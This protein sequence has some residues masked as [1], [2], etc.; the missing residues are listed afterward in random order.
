MFFVRGLSIYVTLIA[1][2]L[3]LALQKYIACFASFFMIRF[4]K[5]FTVGQRIRIGQVK[6]DVRHMGLFHFIVD[7]VGEDEKLGG[8]LTGR[9]IHMPN[10]IALD[11]PILNYSQDYTVDNEL[12]ACEY[13]FDEIR[14]P[15]KADS[16]L[17]KAKEIMTA[18]ITR[19]DKD[20]VDEAK[21]AFKDNCPNFLNEAQQA[22]LV[23]THVEPGRI[24]L[25]GKFVSPVRSKNELKTAI[26]DEFV[27]SLA[28]ENDIHLA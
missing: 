5:L 2:G 28:R 20:F 11:Q 10:L 9:I 17:K 7:E 26:L 13:V 16:N 12:I 18:I 1:I 21:M 6:G 24:W 8:E 23:L 22:P 27:E 14:I 3:A 15:I 25:K 4:G 19:L